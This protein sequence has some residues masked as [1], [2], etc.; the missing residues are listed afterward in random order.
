MGFAV[1]V[2]G[3][4]HKPGH[5]VRKPSFCQ[6]EHT[7]TR[8]SLLKSDTL[9]ENRCKNEIDFSFSKLNYDFVRMIFKKAVAFNILSFTFS[10]LAPGR[11]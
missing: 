4:K 5:G 3:I 1:S 8:S 11:E 2:R 9:K 10:R 7:R 6:C